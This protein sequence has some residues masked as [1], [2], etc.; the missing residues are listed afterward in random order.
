MKQAVAKVEERKEYLSEMME[1]LKKAK[2]ADIAISITKT[3][4]VSDEEI[5]LPITKLKEEFKCIECGDTDANLRYLTT[6]YCIICI[7]K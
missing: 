7:N 2:E 6:E 5:K 1:S 4:K 3:E